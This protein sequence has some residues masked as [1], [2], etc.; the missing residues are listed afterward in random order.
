MHLDDPT[1]ARALGK[2]PTLEGDARE[3]PAFA[4]ELDEFLREKSGKPSALIGDGDDI[5]MPAHGFGILAGK[6]GKGKTTLA[7][8]LAFHLASGRDWL[9]HHVPR[10]LQVLLVENEGPREL[11]RRK[12]ERRR[13]AWPHAVEGDIHV[14]TL[15]WGRFRLDDADGRAKLRAF[16][17]EHEIDL[18]IADPL[19]SFGAHGVGSPDQT[20]EFVRFLVEAGLGQT[21]AFL[22]LHHFRKESAPDELDELSGA[23]AQHADSVLTLAIQ[24]GN[25]SRLGYPKLRWGVAR[26]A[27]TLAFDPETESFEYI[28]DQGGDDRRYRAELVALMENHEDDWRTPR[29]L[30]EKKL[31]GIGASKEKVQDAIGLAYSEDGELN[32]ENVRAEFVVVAGEVAG[33]PQT[34]ALRWTQNTGRTRG[35]TRRVPPG[36][37]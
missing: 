21:T 27:S 18:V 28:F 20:S 36:S 6:S 14:H 7:I 5:L 34:K 1:V 2:P 22:L 16:V 4:L 35:G 24:P 32:A 19:G 15:A 12:L 10:P 29:E 25:R 23:W 3:D 11:F 8:D 13:Q 31:G 33:R 9:G 26:P 17:E 37:T 30:A